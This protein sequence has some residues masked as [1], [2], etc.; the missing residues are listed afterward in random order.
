VTPPRRRRAPLRAA[1]AAAAACLATSGC[2]TVGNGRIAALD[3][4]SA[5]ALLVPGRSTESEVAQ[6]LGPGDVIRFE[7]GYETWHYFYRKG[8]AAGW[9]AVPY[10]N[11]ITEHL[12]A[13]TKELVL[14]FDPGGVLRRW[15]F[16]ASA[17]AVSG[18]GP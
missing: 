17:D 3:G 1:L 12:H 8:I 11:L 14:L 7:S 10:I 18:S 4:T 6:A 2:E 15:S 5:Q 13:P 16:D 9:D